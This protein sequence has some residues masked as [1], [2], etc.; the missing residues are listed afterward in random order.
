MNAKKVIKKAGNIGLSLIVLIAILLGSVPDLT[1]KIDAAPVISNYATVQVPIYIGSGAVTNSYL[2]IY[3][4]RDPNSGMPVYCTRK[5]YSLPTSSYEL[6]N[7]TI[8]ANPLLFYRLNWLYST[9]TSTGYGALPYTTPNTFVDHDPFNYTGVQNNYYFIVN[10]LAVWM[11]LGEMGYNSGTLSG[12]TYDGYNLYD[13]F[14]NG[15]IDTYTQA[16][17]DTAWANS[18]SFPE[19]GRT[20]ARGQRHQLDRVCRIRWRGNQNPVTGAQLVLYPERQPEVLCRS[21]DPD[22][23]HRNP[24]YHRARREHPGRSP[25]IPQNHPA[26]HSV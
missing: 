25:G 18:A 20:Y 10:Q 9:Y 5:G 12:G 4:M 3:A 21:A 15:A 16:E 22:R 2:T 7:S 1:V 26:Q 8:N 11:I 13:A 19:P 14:A 17:F 6:Q 24:V 23:C